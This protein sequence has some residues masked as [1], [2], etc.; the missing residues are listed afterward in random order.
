MYEVVHS[1]RVR[2]P[3]AR[4]IRFSAVIAFFIIRPERILLCHFDRSE[5][6]WRNLF[7]RNK[8]MFRLRP[9]GLRST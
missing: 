3:V 4:F 6:K 2:A 5:A 9:Y 8:K 1:L 7:L